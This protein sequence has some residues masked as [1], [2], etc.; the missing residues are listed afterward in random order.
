MTDNWGKWSSA[1]KIEAIIS[2][3]KRGM[4]AGELAKAI[5]AKYDSQVTRNAVVGIYHRANTG[6]KG[7]AGRSPLKNYPLNRPSAHSDAQRAEAA[8]RRLTRQMEREARMRERAELKKAKEAVKAKQIERTIQVLNPGLVAATYDASCDLP[9]EGYGVHMLELDKE[10]CR[11]PTERIDGVTMFCNH[12]RHEAHQYCR[13]HLERSV[14]VPTPGE[15]SAV[16]E[17][18]RRG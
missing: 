15:R 3:W 1:E 9:K 4:S 6:T 13:S 17:L 18:R 11:W 16:R 8:R 5:S 12:P 2:I 10:G 14:R 7:I